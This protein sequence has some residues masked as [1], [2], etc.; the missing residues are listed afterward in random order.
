MTQE[1]GTVPTFVVGYNSILENAAHLHGSDRMKEYYGQRYR[2]GFYVEKRSWK[3]N[4]VRRGLIT[5]KQG[6][7]F[8][9]ASQ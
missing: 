7:D 6:I 2:S 3:Q 1:F 5:F 4:V 8:L 9:N